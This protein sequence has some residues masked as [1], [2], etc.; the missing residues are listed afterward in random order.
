MATTLPEGQIGDGPWTLRNVA[1]LGTCSLVGVVTLL[2]SWYGAADTG[3][4]SRQMLWLAI[5]VSGT[6]LAALG[7]VAWLLGALRRVRNESRALVG[8]FSQRINP[9]SS[10]AGS[11][12]S[13]PLGERAAAES[14]VVGAGGR[15][16]HRSD[17]PLVRG[18]PLL[19]VSQYQGEPELLGRCGVCQP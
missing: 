6:L 4:W 15:Y 17:C 8:S 10:K 18:K 1:H 7:C 9:E 11:R 13:R 19:P 12:P 14:F 16:L 3:S 2:V 5:G